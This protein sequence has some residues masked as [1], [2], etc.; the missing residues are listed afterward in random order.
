MSARSSIV[1]IVVKVGMLL[2]ALL[3]FTLLLAALP[4][5]RA[6][7]QEEFTQESPAQA[8]DVRHK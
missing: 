1:Q 4:A 8:P 2:G 7:I 5:H 6:P 3:V